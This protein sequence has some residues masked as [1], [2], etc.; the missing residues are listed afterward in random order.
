[1]WWHLG[2]INGSDG[3]KKDGGGVKEDSNGVCDND[4]G[5]TDVRSVVGNDKMYKW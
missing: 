2:I 3:V 5:F 1:M 4:K